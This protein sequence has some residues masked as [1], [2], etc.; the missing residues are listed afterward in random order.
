MEH[1]IFADVEGDGY[2]RDLTRL[3]TIQIAEGPEAPVEVYADQPGFK[4]ISEGLRILK[5]AD[6]IVMHFGLGFDF[7]AI[8]KIYPGT[9]DWRQIIDTVVVSRLM[10]AQSKRH[11]LHDL[12][13]ALGF[14]K[15]VFN[16]FSKFSQEMVTYGKQDVVIL[17][18]AWNGN[19]AKRVYSFQRFYQQYKEAC[20]NEFGV[21]YIIAQQEIGGFRFDYEAAG[22]L[23][24]VLR[25][26]LVDY[27]RHLQEVFPP[28]VTPRYSSKQKDKITG[29][30]KRLKDSVEVFNPGSRQQIAKRL[31]DKYGWKPAEFTDGKSPKVDED[32][33][34]DLPYPEAKI[35]ASYLKTSKKLGMLADGNN[36]WLKLA[37][38][39]ENGD[40][41]I[42]GYVNTLGA[43]THRM[44]H[45]NPNLAQVDKDPRMRALFK[46][47]RGHKQV[48]IDAEGLELR[49]LAHYL[50]LYDGGRYIRSVHSG[51]KADGTDVHTINQNVA[52]LYYRDSA[53][54]M[55]Y[56]H[57]YGCFDKKLGTIVVADAKKA[58]EPIP[59]GS[60]TKIGAKLR[61]K[62]ADGTPGLEKLINK[63]K[64][65]HY[66]KKALPGL[67]NRWIPSASEHS[68]LN[69][70]LQGNGSIVMKK[71]LLIFENWIVER[72]W[73]D[74]VFY[75]ANVHDEFQLSVHPSITQEV[76]ELG[77]QSITQAGI[78]LGVR[79]PLVGDSKIGDNWA[80]T[81]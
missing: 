43:R 42:H 58:G 52:G 19:Q 38:K 26:E 6:K 63:C 67:D 62:L 17:Q 80:E 60:L 23:E 25:Q 47:R 64:H 70:L 77:K 31:I 65:L 53:K 49:M 51:N 10:N 27:E 22:E 32:I 40:Y 7:W 20:E 29:K 75:L 41:F 59:K 54:T 18:Q 57:N 1:I 12:G 45:S 69:T 36:A 21:Q 50:A 3:W 39:D 72:D 24:G 2:L 73:K 28:I 48:G 5:E 13:E 37:R 15:G 78:E 56:A 61:K 44:S 11:S 4:P 46:P 8:E 35:I 30:P 68:A 74:K 14:H 71:A 55:I 79:C 9:I 81:H 34:D 16:D 66:T 76:A 33:L